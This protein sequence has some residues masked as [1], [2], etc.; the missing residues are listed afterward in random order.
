MLLYFLYVFL[1]KISN[2]FKVKKILSWQ[3]LKKREMKIANK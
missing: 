1:Y 2:K 3:I